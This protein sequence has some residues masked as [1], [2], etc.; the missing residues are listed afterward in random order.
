VVLGII[1]EEVRGEIILE[2]KLEIALVK[3][4]LENEIVY[5]LN[6]EEQRT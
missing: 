1:K 5:G 3:T 2:V 6:V 4:L